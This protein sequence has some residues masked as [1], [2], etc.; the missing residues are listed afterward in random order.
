MYYNYSVQWQVKVV[1]ERLHDFVLHIL[2]CV[3]IEKKKININKQ[4]FAL[5]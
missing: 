1:Q 3:K 4:T 5:S 2:F